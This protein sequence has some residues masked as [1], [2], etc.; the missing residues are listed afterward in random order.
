MSNG[1][2]T[3]NE[4]DILNMISRQNAKLKNE[5]IIHTFGIGLTAGGM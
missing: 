2:P 1:E 3:D 4:D 5:V